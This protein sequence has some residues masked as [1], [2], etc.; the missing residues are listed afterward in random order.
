MELGLILA[1]GVPFTQNH[2]CDV[3]ADTLRR[4]AQQWIYA[5]QSW[6]TGP[7]E[8][9]TR[10]LRGLQMLCLLA[11][12]RHVNGLGVSS[13]FFSATSL[14]SLARQMGID[15]D[16]RDFSTLSRC[17]AEL[18]T[19]LW[20]TIV[21]LSLVSCLESGTPILGLGDLSARLPSNI[22]DSELT[23]ESA[24]DEP[25]ATDDGITDMSIQLVLT[26]SQSLRTRALGII[27]DNVAFQ[28]SYEAVVDLADQLRKACAEASAFFS[29]HTKELGPEC[30]FH[31]MYVDMYL[32]KHILLLHRPFMLA[33]RQDP[34][35]YLSRKVCL[36]SCMII[37]SYIN[38][39]STSCGVINFSRM[40]AHG[41]GS[42]CGALSLDVIVTLGY[43]LNTQLQ[44]E[45]LLQ[46][47]TVYDPA[48]EL[49]RAGR[50][51]IIHRLEHI[52]EQL[53]KSIAQGNSSLKKLIIVS[54]IL[55][56]IN[57]LESGGNVRA[58]LH[59]AVKEGIQVCSQSLERYL[60]QHVPEPFDMDG[61]TGTQAD[62]ELDTM[63]SFF[64]CI[65]VVGIKSRSVEMW[66]AS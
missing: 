26:K 6:L 23:D 18:I 11:I 36:E 57:A 50:E 10:N 30:M 19:R 63:V 48:R 9:S 13:S 24:L 59:Y 4:S 31:R 51:P 44:E 22:N 38:E 17:Q 49:A 16:T 5:A 33:A 35:F 28:T 65:P 39:D 27:N 20:S 40:M 34:R 53:T 37:A 45:E 21:E 61:A 54:A 29:A 47:P 8:K 3:D 1:I 14:I 42:L 46:E 52:Q 60:A 43:E 62:L 56:Q 2:E 32:R 15:R 12:A 25:S 58:A 41:S 55:A 66:L 7:A 64:L